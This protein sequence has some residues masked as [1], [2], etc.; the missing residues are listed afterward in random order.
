MSELLDNFAFLNGQPAFF[1]MVFWGS[2]IL[3]LLT[4]LTFL[5]LVWSHLIYTYSN[6]RT[7]QLLDHWEDLFKEMRRGR[8][9]AEW[10]KVSRSDKYYLLE[11]W[12]DQRVYAEGS[13][14][15]MLDELANRLAFENTVLDILLPGV[16]D[17]FPRKVWLQAQAIAATEFIDTERAFSAVADMAESDNQFL[18]IQACA[19]M[20]RTMADGYERAIISIMMRYPGEVPEIFTRLSQSGGSDVLHIMEP[21]LDRL[22]H[23]TLMNFIS[24]AEQSGDDSLIQVLQDRLFKQPGDEE[25]AALLRSLGRLGG[26]EQRPVIIPYLQH[27]NPIVRTQAAKAMG[28][29][30]LP[31]DRDLLVPLLSDRNWWVRYRTARAL[32]KLCDFDDEELRALQQSLDDRY[33]RDMITHAYEE[34]EWHQA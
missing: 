5:Y 32:V 20:A 10:P 33:A 8:E 19:C 3:I 29:I 14:A 30:G 18:A 24:L 7:Q 4:L 1:I 17:F 21:F 25:T 28:R 9:P 13:Y 31:E 22:P 12:L 6:F 2:L 34:K 23:V 15:R 11:L 26:A 27:T 16:F